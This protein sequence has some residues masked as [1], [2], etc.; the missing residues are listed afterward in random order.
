VFHHERVMMG[1]RNVFSSR[2][3]KGRIS[4]SLGYHPIFQIVI[5]AYRMIQR[6]YLVGGLLQIA[7]YFWEALGSAERKVPQPVVEFLQN[8]QMQRLRLRRH[9]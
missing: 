3:R 2:F 9:R 5:G 8:E 1:G 7:G 4:Y 6:P